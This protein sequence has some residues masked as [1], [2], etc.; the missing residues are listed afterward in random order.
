MDRFVMHLPVRAVFGEA[1]AEALPREAGRLGVRRVMLCC[2]PGGRGRAQALADAL[3]EAC[4]GVFDGAQP[5]CPEA[6]VGD[7]LDRFQRLD[8]DGAVTFGGGATIGLGKVIA[9]RTGKPVIAVPTSYAGSEMTAV[10]GILVGDEKRTRTDENCMA[11]TAIYD[12]AL[13][14]SLSAHV[15]LTSG[16]NSLAHCVEALY[17]E[18]ANPVAAML[19]EAGLRAHAAGLEAS[20]ARPDDIAAR[21]HAHYGAMLGGAALQLAGIA[22]HH[23]LC[24]VLG[25][26]HGIPHG[27]SNTVMLPH[28]VAYNAGAAP[29]AMAAL[30]RAL[31]TNDPA[32]ALYD[33]A[34]RLDGPTRLKDLGMAEADLD[35]AADLAVKATSWNPRPVD[36]ASVRAMLAD[37]FN[38]RRP[39]AKA[40][41]GRSV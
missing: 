32:G 5:H 34:A 7:A 29:H 12:P 18:R 17:Q 40:S 20:V 24:H 26:R 28:V 23:K 37:A 22:L 15:T 2:T 3:G 36:V 41:G 39:T 8:A 35:S 6:V 1:V 13:T 30:R 38:G 9:V 31:E 10:Y 27:E 21:R 4:V 11:R 19:A 25:G 33:L 14:L 16:M